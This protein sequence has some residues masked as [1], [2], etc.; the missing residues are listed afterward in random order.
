MKKS[1]TERWQSLR[2]E[3]EEALRHLWSTPELPM[4]E[5]RSAAYLT[6]W[7]ENHGFAVE[8]GVGGLPTAFVASYGSALSPA[9]GLLAEYDAMPGLSL[10]H[11]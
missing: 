2:P 6:S 8:S 3:I 1:V 7:L 10:I 11:I 9:V 5:Y 4:M